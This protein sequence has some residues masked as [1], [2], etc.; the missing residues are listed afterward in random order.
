MSETQPSTAH[1]VSPGVT[2]LLPAH[3]APTGILDFG[4][5]RVRELVSVLPQG[6]PVERLRH[7]HRRLQEL[8]RPVYT[9][10]ELQPVS[11]TLANGKGSCSQ[12][13][14]C[15][16]AVARA[17]GVATRVRAFQVDGRFW[18]PRFSPLVRLFIPRR[19]LLAWPQFHL[20]GSWLD[21]DELFGRT[22]DLV[23]AAPGG[24]TNDGETL[25]EAISHTSVD[26]LGKTKSCGV[27]CDAG[28]D[29]SQHVVSDE[30]FFDS[31]DVLFGTRPLLQQAVRG[32]VFEW[33]WGGRKSA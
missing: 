1:P 9:L 26:F 18:Y 19:I 21:L 14:A 8:V 12:R 6:T 29:L 4:N 31:R 2:T 22:P 15:L 17:I 30:G 20:D 27:V 25:F 28:F 5:A 32:R 13:I 10:D 33:I 23:T 7:A 3:L 16:E 24:F 11:T